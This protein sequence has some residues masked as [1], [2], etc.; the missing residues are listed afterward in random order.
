MKRRNQIMIGLAT[1]ITAAVVIVAQPL[2]K[3]AQAARAPMQATAA[4]AQQAP[5][6]TVDVARNTTAKKA[7]PTEITLQREVFEYDRSGRRDP[8]KSLMTSSEVRPLLSDLRLTAVAFDPDG[9]NSV[10]ILRDSFSKQQ[11]RI[12]VGQQLGRLRVSGIKQKSVQ[13]TIEEF[14]FNRQETLALAGDTTKVRN[15]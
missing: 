12:R 13:F 15:P 9:D 7:M 5:V 11:Y 1:A 2:V 4:G 10:A 3:E 6:Q 14:G 8:Y